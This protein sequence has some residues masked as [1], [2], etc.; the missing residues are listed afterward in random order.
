MLAR[1]RFSQRRLSPITGCNQGFQA[2]RD[3]IACRVFGGIAHRME[4]NGAT[5][6]PGL[7]AKP[8]I[9]M[10]VSVAQLQPI[11][12]HAEPLATLGYVHVR[13]ADDAFLKQDCLIYSCRTE[14]ASYHARSYSKLQFLRREKGSAD[15][16]IRSNT[17]SEIISVYSAENWGASANTSSRSRSKRRAGRHS[18]PF[19]FVPL[20]I[21]AEIL[22][23]AVQT[24]EH[25][26]LPVG[27][28]F[29]K[30]IKD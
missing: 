3:R 29:E 17:S 13:H 30:A 6:V 22:P 25:R 5:A 9:D 11:H 28:M 10:P 20:H 23:D 2:E 7:E 19:H 14:E 18:H 12:Y 8:I 1:P 24:P 4:H 16:V 27:K 15:P 21:A 26:Q